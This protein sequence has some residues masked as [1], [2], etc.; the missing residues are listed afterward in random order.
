MD[1][2]LERTVFS[3]SRAAEFLE[4]RA[5]QAQTGRG[6]EHFGDVVAKELGDNALDEAETA[7]VMPEI[8]IE[9]DDDYI[10]ISDNGRGFAPEIIERV[11]DFGHADER[12]GGVPIANARAPRK[13]LENRPRHRSRAQPRQARADRLVRH[14][15]PDHGGRQSRRRRRHRSQVRPEQPD[16]RDPDQRSGQPR[17]R[18]VVASIRDLQSASE[19]L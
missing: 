14:P 19:R 16:G 15:A 13:C 3:T 1:G 5:L 18:L 17:G 10:R 7:G 2:K 12:Q 4:E 8:E 6:R 11:L 9:Q